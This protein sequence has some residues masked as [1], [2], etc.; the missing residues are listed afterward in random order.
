MKNKIN[1][2]F[3][4][5]SFLTSGSLFAQT[6]ELTLEEVS[7]SVK[8]QNFGVL[9]NAMKLYQAKESIS[10]A[11]G[12]LLPKLNIWKMVSSVIDPMALVGMIQDIAPFL[13]P[14]NWFRLEQSKI[15]YKA[16]LEGY[17]ALWGNELLTAKSLYL[18]VL[19]DQSLMD[20]IQ[21]AALR[22]KELEDIIK[23][24]EMMGSAPKGSTRSVQMKRLALESDL[25]EMGVL[26]KKERDEL[27]FALGISNGKTVALKSVALPSISAEKPLESSAFDFRVKNASPEL[28]QFAHLIEVIPSIKKEVSFSFLGASSVSRGVSGGVFDHLPVQD[29]LGFGAGASL[30]IISTEKKIL[31]VQM[32]ALRETLSR[33]LNLVVDRHNADLTQATNLA[34]RKKLAE[35]Q[36][37]MFKT[38]IAMGE[39]IEFGTLIEVTES[40]MGVNLL[41]HQL[42]YR[43]LINKQ[44]LE[45]LLLDG[46]YNKTPAS[47]EDLKGDQ[48]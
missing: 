4:S 37:Q 14:A 31:D 26:L 17:R 13:V 19:L 3:F 10:V 41:I 40:A 12:N 48:S 29:G 1:S 7:Q 6:K 23:V 43:F 46:D 28:R 44:K 42:N 25:A 15:L 39:A 34:Q 24:R 11:R 33:Q 20:S 9:K 18:Q 16:E 22:H 30:K 36:W 8:A 47:L 35:E 2:L 27:T 45:R 21:N 5:L 32:E 38:Q